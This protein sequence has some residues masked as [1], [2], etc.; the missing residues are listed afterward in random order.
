ML[1]I[2]PPFS[3]L[4]DEN[5]DINGKSSSG[6]HSGPGSSTTKYPVIVFIHGDVSYDRD[7]GNSYDGSIWASYGRVIVVTLNYRLGVLGKFSLT[8]IVTEK[9]F[10]MFLYNNFYIFHTFFVCL[11]K[12]ILKN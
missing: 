7:T 2:F 10:K 11:K 1:S 4:V 5:G 3:F 6:G 8:N 9:W 12:S